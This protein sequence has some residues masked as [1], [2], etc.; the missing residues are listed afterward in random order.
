MNIISGI[1]S[2]AIAAAIA[3]PTDVLKVWLMRISIEFFYMN[4]TCM[5]GLSYR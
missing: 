4:T 2:G 1:S 5:C 3:N